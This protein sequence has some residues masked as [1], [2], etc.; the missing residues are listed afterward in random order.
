MRPSSQDGDV[1][2]ATRDVLTGVYHRAA[3]VGGVLTTTGRIHD[4]RARSW[5]DERVAT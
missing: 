5:V 4:G 1:D 2:V 3:D